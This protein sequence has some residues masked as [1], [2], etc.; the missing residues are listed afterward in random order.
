MIEE[1]PNSDFSKGIMVFSPNYFLIHFKGL[2]GVK[3]NLKSV[4]EKLFTLRSWE[5]RKE[6]K[7]KGERSRTHQ[8]HQDH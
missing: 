3:L 8:E 6:K 4:L 2:L 1:G 5:K 7:E